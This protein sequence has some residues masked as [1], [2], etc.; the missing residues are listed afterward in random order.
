MYLAQGSV[1][2]KKAYYADYGN[3]PVETPGR[4]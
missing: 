2:K 1:Q 4:L 3:C